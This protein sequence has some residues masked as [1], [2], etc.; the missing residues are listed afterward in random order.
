M[1]FMIESAVYDKKQMSSE[2][3]WDPQLSWD[4]DT[5]LSQFIIGNEI[6]NMI[7]FN[8]SHPVPCS[9]TFTYLMS[10]YSSWVDPYLC[11]HLGKLR[12]FFHQISHRFLGIYRYYQLPKYS[13]F[14]LTIFALIFDLD[15]NVFTS[16][17]TL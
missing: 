14:C 17:L 11:P 12:R 7:K 8:K 6:Q 5:F 3:V 2:T 13:D 15:I 4:Q 16:I 10:Q 9:S 1:L